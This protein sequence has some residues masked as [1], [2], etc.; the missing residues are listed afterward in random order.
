MLKG[1]KKHR[2]KE[3]GKTK[4]EAPRCVNYKATENKNHIGTTALERSVVYSTGVGGWVRGGLKAFHCTNFILGPIKKVHLCY[5]SVYH[6]G[7]NFHDIGR[8]AAECAAT[9]HC[10]LFQASNKLCIKFLTY[11]TLTKSL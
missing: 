9:V 3:Q 6:F 8:M 7:L 11:M 1:Q 10:S 2:D 4:H 5:Q